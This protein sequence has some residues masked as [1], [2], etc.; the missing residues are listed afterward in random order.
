MFDTVTIKAA[1]RGP[2][3]LENLRLRPKRRLGKRH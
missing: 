3:G 2:R 1:S